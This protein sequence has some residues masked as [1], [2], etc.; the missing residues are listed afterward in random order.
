MDALLTAEV[1]QQWGKRVAQWR[2]EKEARRKL[3]D[4]VMQTRR[5]QVQEKC[6]MFQPLCV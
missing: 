4:D 2:K 6:E 5:Q 3:M 1:E